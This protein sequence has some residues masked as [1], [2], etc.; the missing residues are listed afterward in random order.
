MSTSTVC[1]L[2]DF[3][4][5]R[6]SIGIPPSAAR[7]KARRAK[8][9]RGL[10]GLLFPLLAL[11]FFVSAGR[12]QTWTALAHE[13]LFVHGS[14]TAMLMTDGTV[15]VHD[16]C[17]KNWFKLTP[18]NTG[19]YVNGTWSAAIPMQSGH[20]PQYFSSA[21]L[22]DGRLVVVGGEYNEYCSA[23]EA[24]WTNLSDIYDPAT[25][26]WSVLTPPSWTNV[27]DAQ[28][29]V[30]PN[31]NFLLANPFG[32]DLA[33]LSPSTL[34]WSYP[35]F[36]G[37]ADQQDEEG[38]TLLP[39]GNILTV[40]AVDVPNSEI[41]SVSG[42]TWST[43]G[44]TIHSLVDAGTA[45]I[46]PAVL[47]PDGT[48]VAFGWT[49]YTSVYNTATKVWTAGPVFPVESSVQIVAAD[50]P[51]ALLPSGK[52][53][54]AASGVFTNPTYFFEFDGTNLNSVPSPAN[55]SNNPSFVYRFLVLPKG[56]VLTTDG[57][58]SV[59]IYTPAG[60]PNDAWRPT[61]SSAP[62]F[63]QPGNT[64]SISGTQFNGLS[65]GAAYGDDAQSATNFPLVR[66]TNTASGHVFYN[67][68]HD[69]STMAV[70][71]GNATVST[72]FDASSAL[73]S[74]ASTLNVV[75]NGIVST[76]KDVYVYTAPA[77]TT[78]NGGDSLTGSS[79][80]FVWSA[81]AGV[82]AFKLQVGTTGAGASDVYNGASTTDTSATVPNIPLNGQTLYVTLNYQVDGTW[83]DVQYT[84]TEAST[85]PSMTSPVPGNVVGTTQIFTWNPGAGPTQFILSVGTTGVAAGDIYFGGPFSSTSATVPGIPADGKPLYVRLYYEILGTWYAIDYLYT[86]PTAIPPSMDTPANGIK[87]TG[88][89]QTFSWKPGAYV[90]LYSLKIGTTGA[91]SHDYYNGPWTKR[92]SVGFT[93]VPAHGAPLYVR[94]L[95][96]VGTTWYHIDY[97]Y[98]EGGAPTPPD[99]NLPA[100]GS[101]LSATNVTFGWGAGAGVSRYML[102]LG[103]TG[104]GSNDV[105]DGGWTKSLSVNFSTFPAHGAGLY[106]RLFYEVG[107]TW[108]HIDYNYTEGGTPTPPSMTSPTPLSSFGG[109]SVT[110]AWSP[111]VGPLR[112]SLKVG[113][114]GPGSSDVYNGTSSKSTSIPV[115]TL[116]ATAKPIYVRLLYEV[117]VTWYHVDYTY[118]YT[119]P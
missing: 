59:Y 110:F 36:T 8:S 80:S 42:G 27:G 112:Y 76:S 29:V 103:T 100:P 84:Y 119:G 5:S 3:L 86:D 99:L 22:S 6:T 44:S 66:I 68:T 114:T 101:T 74:G 54:V 15:M 43:A 58:G 85:L 78:P 104:V 62:F 93:D 70:A 73:E 32:T 9:R 45:E 48:V 118:T 81:G 117:N 82:S 105:Y 18:D 115:T 39:N 53:L 72:H 30:L 50:A 19:S 46:G 49:Q 89:T 1:P 107:T 106:A 69:H 37:K 24:T 95:Y 33:E 7:T 16:Y 55:A 108:Y 23:G 79:Q 31:G 97:N 61:I 41:Y 75:T 20:T 13:P 90:A 14:S 67:K 71:T 35:S 40:D 2:S 65:Q 63:I 113:T 34:T 21:V 92:T 102:K 4:C 109:S 10:S 11:V 57:S 38:F 94:L 60:T 26:S 12:A 98:T 96:E 64:F 17:T 83:L 56:Q 91:G 87:L 111:G 88:S 52:V 116:P 25:N 77:I 51:A 47:R 28:N